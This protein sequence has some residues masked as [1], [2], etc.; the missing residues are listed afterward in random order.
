MKLSFRYLHALMAVFLVAAVSPSYAFTNTI[1]LSQQKIQDRVDA[2]FPLTV[3]DPIFSLR[4]SQP[5]VLLDAHNNKIGM[6]IS[7]EIASNSK[8]IALGSGELHGRP[9]YKKEEG[10]FYL[11]HPQIRALQMDGLSVRDIRFSLIM[12]IALASILTEIPI[13]KLNDNKLRERFAKKRLQSIR[14]EDGVF[15]ME[16]NFD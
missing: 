11:Q 5:K 2:F 3:G 13:Y 14:V 15:L 16:F 4:F 12:D 1:E 10:G 9:V 6:H 8:A 7:I